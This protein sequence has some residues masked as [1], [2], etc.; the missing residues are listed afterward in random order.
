MYKGLVGYPD[1][2]FRTPTMF[3]CTAARNEFLT[4]FPYLKELKKSP[5]FAALLE[6]LDGWQFIG[7]D[8]DDKPYR[9][10]LQSHTVR[11]NT[12]GLS[13]TSILRSQYFRNTLAF[14][15]LLAVRAAWQARA[16]DEARRMH[17][18]DVWPL[19]ARIARADIAAMAVRMGFELLDA[20]QDPLWR[21]ILGDALGDVAQDYARTLD[22]TATA[23]DDDAALSAAFLAWFDRSERLH[24]SDAETLADMDMG[25]PALLWDGRGSLSEGAVRCLTVD[26]VCG[27]SYLGIHAGEIAGDPAWS[28]MIDPINQAHFLQIIDE[29]GTTRVGSLSMRDEELAKRLFPG[30]LEQV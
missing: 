14:N 12:R 10:D 22:L 9:I 3:D 21:H 15:A 17:R 25:L 11:I 30:L 26:P 27:S 20:N 5:S 13:A 23:D 4:A 8:L 29:I 24:V 2:P 6:D 1:M 7:A 16:E 28:D 19:I 18:P